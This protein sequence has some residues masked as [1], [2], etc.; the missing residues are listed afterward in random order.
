MGLELDGAPTR[1]DIFFLAMH[2]VRPC[3]DGEPRFEAI[4]E[5]VQGCTGATTLQSKLRSTS[6]LISLMIQ[7]NDA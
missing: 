5:M 2:A 3:A 6:V 1:A 4:H 7:F